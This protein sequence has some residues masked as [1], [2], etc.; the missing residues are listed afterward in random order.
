M[1]R[2]CGERAGLVYVCNPNNPTGT[3]VSG[4]ALLAFLA[5]SRRHGRGRRRAYHHF[6]E[7][8]AYRSAVGMID[9]HPNVVVARTFSKVYGLAGMRLGYAVASTANAEA[10]PRPRLVE[11]RERGRP[12]RGP[13]LPGRRGPGSR[14]SGRG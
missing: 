5:R 2:A 6:V 4:E 9:R 1:A 11:Q 12:R 13:R 8:P 3:I 10:L 14:A 7:D